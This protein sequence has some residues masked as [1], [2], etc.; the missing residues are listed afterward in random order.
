MYIRIDKGEVLLNKKILEEYIDACKLIEE[1]EKD[2]ER[3]NKKKQMVIQTNVS[4]SNP[5]FP[6]QPKHFRIAGK[7]ITYQEDAQLRYEEKLLEERKAKAEQIKIKVQQFMNE[8]P[9]RMQRIVRMKYFEGKTWEYVA[10]EL[11]RGATTD[12]VRMELDRFLEKK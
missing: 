11:G 1:T 3:L 10:S 7:P 4:G 8:I 6:Y 9:I 5:E 2:I 12:S